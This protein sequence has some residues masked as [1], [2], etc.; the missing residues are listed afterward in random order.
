MVS[1]SQYK[2]ALGQLDR[3]NR[4]SLLYLEGMI[5]EKFKMAMKVNKPQLQKIDLSKIESKSDSLQKQINGLRKK[6]DSVHRHVQE[7]DHDEMALKTMI[8]GAHKLLDEIQEHFMGLYESGYYREG[9]KRKIR[10]EGLIK[11]KS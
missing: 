3:Y 6:M 8:K 9:M 2:E 1:R 5:D 11:R 7:H 4:L 10:D